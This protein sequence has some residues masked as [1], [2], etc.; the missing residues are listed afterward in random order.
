LNKSVA[1]LTGKPFFDA[2]DAKD[3]TEINVAQ[4]KPIATAVNLI[5]TLPIDESK[6]YLSWCLINS[7]AGYLSDN[8]V[9]ANFDFY[10]KQLSGRKVLQ[11]RWNVR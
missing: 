9:N 4:V 8:F 5:H 11:P 1:I 2:A 3:F 10:G 6:A 7:A